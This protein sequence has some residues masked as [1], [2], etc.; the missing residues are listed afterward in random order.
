MSRPRR[1]RRDIED[2]ARRTLVEHGLF[3]CPVNPVVVARRLGATVQ[4][5]V[6][7]EERLAG[8]TRLR[9]EHAVILVKES[10]QPLRKRFT[11]A[12]EI[13]HVLLHIDKDTV[14]IIDSDADFFRSQFE[15]TAEWTDVRQRE[16]EANMFAAGLLMPADLVREVWNE[17]SEDSRSVETLSAL[18]QVSEEAMGYRLS[19]IGLAG[20]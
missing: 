1:D 16:V 18:F 20:A 2:L 13:G 8:L 14:E 5:A 9:G 6:F 15:D 10:D 7:S 3:A 4:N 12:H 17:L 19:A 11:I